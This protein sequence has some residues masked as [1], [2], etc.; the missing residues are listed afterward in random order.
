MARGGTK[1]DAILAATLAT[2]AT[3]EAAA[4]AAGVS[5]RTVARRLADPAFRRLVDAEQDDFEDTD[6]DSDE[7]DTVI[8]RGFTGKTLR[9]VRNEWTQHIEEHPEE[10]SKFPE[11]M[12]KALA[13]SFPPQANP[14]GL[15]QIAQHLTPE[16]VLQPRFMKHANGATNVFPSPVA[17]SAI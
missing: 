7:D 16:L 2:G 5:L 12:M 4:T 9:A 10:L 17:I 1:T 11:Q 6:E 15:I 8:S 14:E 13:F 3:N